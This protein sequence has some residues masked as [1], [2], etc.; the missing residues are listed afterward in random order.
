MTAE[1]RADISFFWKSLRH[2]GSVSAARR[3]QVL[4]LLADLAAAEQEIIAL[5]D[6]LQTA[7]LHPQIP[8]NLGKAWCDATRALLT[9]QPTEPPEGGSHD[10]V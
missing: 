1:E 9:P 4:T 8:R 10:A 2:D 7:L 6:L 5:K 3:K